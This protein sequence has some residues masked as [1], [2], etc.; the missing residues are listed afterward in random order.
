M[1]EDMGKD[2]CAKVVAESKFGLNLHSERENAMEQYL[3]ITLVFAYARATSQYQGDEFAMD[4]ENLSSHFTGDQSGERL[5]IWGLK[6]I[7]FIEDDGKGI[8][9][10]SDEGKEYLEKTFSGDTY[11]QTIKIK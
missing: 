4:V 5:A 3:D 11:F 7:G 6:C 2:L 8:Y 10:A 1:E 9:Q